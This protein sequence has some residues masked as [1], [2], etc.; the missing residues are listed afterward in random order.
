MAGHI[1]Y[2]YFSQLRQFELYTLCFRNKL[3]G[4]SIILDVHDI[5]GIKKA[6]TEI[7]PDC[8]INCIG[9]LIKGSRNNLENAIYINAYFPHIL[10]RIVRESGLTARI[11]HISTDC[12]FSG[13]RGSYSDTDIKDALDVYGMTKNIGEIIDD[14]NLTIRTSIIG[15]ELKAN[16]EGLFHWVFSQRDKGEIPGYEKS[17]WAGVTTLELAKAIECCIKK[18]ITGLFQLTNGEK[19]SKYELLQLLVR[20]FDLHITVRKLAGKES[21]KSIQPSSR[22]GFDYRVP[23]YTAMITELCY[24]MYE[25][26]TLYTQYLRY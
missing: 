1:V 26:K 14:K 22:A 3:I 12:V 4:N 19:I 10:S 21:D 18:N 6:I 8:I 13:D 15:P 2:Y 24:F 25:H 7:I 23:S 20:K 5:D 9:V 11:V 17:L 16:G